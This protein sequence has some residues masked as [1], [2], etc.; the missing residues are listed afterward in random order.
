M[1]SRRLSIL[2]KSLLKSDKLQTLLLTIMAVAITYTGGKSFVYS[3]AKSLQVADYQFP[4]SI[5]L[6]QWNFFSS[7]SINSN[8][9]HSLLGE[10]V[11]GKH[12]RYQQNGK[13]LEISMRYVVDTDGNLNF[14]SKRTL[15]LSPSLRED[16]A[17]GFY[18]VYVDSNKANLT[19]C[20]NPSGGS[21]VTDDRFRRNRML[22][23]NHLERI[24]PWLRGQTELQDKRC[25]SA[26]LSIDLDR[27]SLEEDYR[28]LES[29]WFDWYEYWQINYPEES[30][31]A[32]FTSN[33]LEE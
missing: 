23:D 29:V 22:Y 28:I 21:T 2:E 15:G 16:G 13:Y 3:E 27:N 14:I 30:R 19:A 10:F 1:N 9:T 33:E 31:G 4:E 17:G 6:S 26:H 11:S 8:L 18:S 12:Y 7:K 24:V 25:L 5:A 20:I 32:S